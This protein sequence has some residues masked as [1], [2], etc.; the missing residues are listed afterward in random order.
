MKETVYAS[1][2]PTR[3]SKDLGD[4][5]AIYIGKSFADCIGLKDNDVVRYMD[6]FLFHLLFSY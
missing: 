3:S 1:W 2:I 4:G 5:Q 6:F